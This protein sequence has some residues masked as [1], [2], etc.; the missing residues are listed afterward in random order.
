VSAFADAALAHTTR[1]T[2]LTKPAAEALVAALTRACKG[3]EKSKLAVAASAAVAPAARA[4]LEA[5]GVAVLACDVM[6]SDGVAEAAARRRSGRKGSALPASFRGSAA[7]RPEGGQRSGVRREFVLEAPYQLQGD[8]ELAVEKLVKGFGEERRRFMT[9][10]G[11]TGTGKSYM[12]ACTV[13]ALGKQTLVLA[14]NKLLAA[15]LV[16]VASSGSS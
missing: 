8:Q 13:A 9:L 1:T 11:C 6:K 10:H 7:P 3:T 16:R 12:L 14:P 5:C 15:Q 2:P 4:W